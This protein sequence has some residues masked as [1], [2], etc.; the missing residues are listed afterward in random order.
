MTDIPWDSA[1]RMAAS[2]SAPGCIQMCVTPTAAASSTT[3]YVMAGCVITE[4][5]FGF[6]GSDPSEG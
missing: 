6:T 3:R 4:M 5:A 2:L 1:V